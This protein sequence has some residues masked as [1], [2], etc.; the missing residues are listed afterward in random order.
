MG[1]RF[2]RSITIVPGIRINLT[3][4]G[5]STTVGPR[6]AS[7]NI[8]PRGTYANLGLRGTGLSTRTRLDSPRSRGQARSNYREIQRA[9]R[10]E[11][12]AAARQEATAAHEAHER[13][14][15][16]LRGI[17][18][19]R[20]QQAFD[21]QA[22]K[23]PQPFT[24]TPFVPRPFPVTERE[25]RGEAAARRPYWP[26]VSGIGLAIGIV[27]NDPSSFGA[28]GVAVPI[29]LLCAALA[30][31]THTSRIQLANSLMAQRRAEHSEAIATARAEH[32]ARED[33]KR[34]ECELRNDFA[35]RLAAAEAQGEPE[36]LAELLEYELSHQDL[37][38]PLVFELAFDGIE[39]VSLEI[40]LPELDAIP[41]ERTELTKTGNLSHRKLAK[42]D[43]TEMY[44]AVCASL[45]LRLVH[46]TFRIL[47][48]LT[49]VEVFGTTDGVDPA[50]GHQRE[51]VALHVAIT[52]DAFN[53]LNLDDVEPEAALLGLGGAFA[54]T[55]SGDRRSLAGVLGLRAESDAI[56]AE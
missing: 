26:S 51:Y 56:D 29:T 21:W 10:E 22:A 37:P 24:R 55:K 11:E 44:A 5:L 16:G 39:T 54:H 17:L 47:P 49:T 23:T 7:I 31:W 6:G 28:Y 19:A 46:E 53:R 41:E 13:E 3:T 45:A 30:W 35:R 2:R 8:G 20:E 14:F 15:D 43:R 36:P 33:E 50:T 9:I 42:R 38:V 32:E 25:I 1:L 34:Y 18:R 27:I 12:R 4:H 48:T 52:R 40:S